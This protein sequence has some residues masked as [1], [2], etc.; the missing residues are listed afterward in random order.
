MESLQ[1]LITPSLQEF[2]LGIQLETTP[3]DANK[4]NRKRSVQLDDAGR[5]KR[6]RITFDA[7]QI[8]ELEKVFADNQ[9]PDA[10]C[11]DELASKI[12]LHEERV[13]IWFQ[14][15]RAKYRRE[16]KHATRDSENSS[17]KNDTEQVK[18]AIEEMINN[19]NN[20][21]ENGKST[22][23]DSPSS[24]ESS[25]EVRYLPVDSY[26]EEDITATLRLLLSGGQPSNETNTNA[27]GNTQDED[28]DKE[29]D[30]KLLMLTLSHLFN[31]Q[32]ETLIS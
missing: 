16:M 8:E 26:N 27:S 30:T 10:A 23:K 21:I 5:K 31:I 20:V 13:Q 28:T 24:T 19:N 11:R 12:Q 3:C 22:G 9:Y 29:E 17:E 14:N 7:S 2:L 6:N 1:G 25:E 32:N 18:T 4:K 15:R